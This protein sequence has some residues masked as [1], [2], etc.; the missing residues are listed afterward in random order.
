MTTVVIWSRR[1]MRVKG[2]TI[3]S[4][5][6][7][8]WYTNTHCEVGTG[9]REFVSLCLSLVF[10]CVSSRPENQIPKLRK[11]IFRLLTHATEVYIVSRV[12]RHLLVSEGRDV[13]GRN[14]T[15]DGRIYKI[16]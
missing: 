11:F 3:P 15:H 8:L 12:L 14:K 16:R 10:V 7:S 2:S 1:E 13:G 9:R 6:Q 5:A 4:S